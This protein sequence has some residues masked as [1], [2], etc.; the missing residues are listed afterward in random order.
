[1]NQIEAYWQRFCESEGLQ[2]IRYKEAFQFG[3]KADWLAELVVDGVKRAT[4]SSFPLYELEEESLPE[5]GD[6]QIVLN[7][8][9][10]PVAIIQ[11]YSIEI[12][13]FNEVPVDFALA[14]GEGTYEE[15]KEAHV[16][17]FSRELSKLGLEFTEEMLTVCD[18]FKK[19]FPK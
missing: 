5:V 14:E 8:H 4:C 17:F 15:W 10:E 16:A 9:D 3:E 13:P 18:R 2:N 19:V 1:M 12:Y 11:S 7:S 6:Y